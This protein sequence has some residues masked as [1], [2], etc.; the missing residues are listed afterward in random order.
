MLWSFLKCNADSNHR[1]NAHFDKYALWYVPEVCFSFIYWQYIDIIWCK[2][3]VPPCMDNYLTL[4][5][6]GNTIDE[7]FS[8]DHSST[9][10]IIYKKPI[11]PSFDKIIFMVSLIKQI[12]KH[13]H[14]ERLLHPTKVFTNTWS[15][16]T[17]PV[18]YINCTPSFARYI[19]SQLSFV[20]IMIV[21]DFYFEIQKMGIS[22]NFIQSSYHF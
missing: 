14:A 7:D 5:L 8:I 19:I 1:Y 20:S 9:L 11:V 15:C 6:S 10:C 13:E 2:G 3:L 12:I 18:P 17:R 22:F 16:M 21:A 4:L